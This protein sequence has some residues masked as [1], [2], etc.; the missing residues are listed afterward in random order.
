M[1]SSGNSPKTPSGMSGR[2]LRRA[3]E[4]D[5]SPPR[6]SERHRQCSVRGKKDATLVQ[7]E[8]KEQHMPQEESRQVKEEAASEVA[9]TREHPL[10]QHS[11]QPV[12]EGGLTTEDAW[13]KALEQL[14]EAL[15]ASE[16]GKQKHG[17]TRQRSSR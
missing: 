15:P 16:G 10:E 8:R 7:A 4:E 5:Y 9:E 13:N 12:G 3:I 17:S 11:P 6:T 1:D 2:V 14:Q